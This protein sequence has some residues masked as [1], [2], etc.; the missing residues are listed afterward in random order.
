[1]KGR[2]F[3]GPKGVNIEFIDD[4]ENNEN[5][6]TGNQKV[7]YKVYEKEWIISS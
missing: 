2:V 7:P 5:E 1:M 4:T 3:E 6:N